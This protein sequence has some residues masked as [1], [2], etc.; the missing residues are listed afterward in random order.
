MH[1]VLEQYGL[2]GQPRRVVASYPRI[3]GIRSWQLGQKF[4]VEVSAPIVIELEPGEAVDPPALINSTMLVM[5]NDLVACIRDAGVTNFDAYPTVLRDPAAGREWRDYVSV[6]VIGLVA[7]ADFKQSSYRLNDS[8]PMINVDF[9]SLVIDETKALGLKMFR[10][11]ECVTAIIIDD[12]TKRHLETHGF[13]M[14][15]FV[16]TTEWAG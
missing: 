4:E 8:R 5:R 9:D 14:L 7:A 6:N 16:P 12:A 15:D 13:K 11:A 10:L 2:D 1:Y 3:R